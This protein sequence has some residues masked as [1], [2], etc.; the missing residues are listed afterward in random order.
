LT[1]CEKE[2]EKG[3]EEYERNKTNKEIS[4]SDG[5]FD[6]GNTNFDLL[7]TSISNVLDK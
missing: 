6:F 4:V 2:K 5:N 1:I 7:C 3:I